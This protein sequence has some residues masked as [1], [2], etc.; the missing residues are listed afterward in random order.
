MPAREQNQWLVRGH[1][2]LKTDATSVALEL[3][4]ELF[5]L[6]WVF[7][8]LGLLEFLN[9]LDGVIVGIFFRLAVVEAA[10][11][12]FPFHFCLPLFP[13]LLVSLDLFF[14]FL[15]SPFP[16]SHTICLFNYFIIKGDI[17]IGL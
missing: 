5:I 6:E 13:F 7:L 3:I 14:L 15:V 2:E 4:L 1:H 16:V 9:E 8:A 10:V 11:L 12:L 17:R